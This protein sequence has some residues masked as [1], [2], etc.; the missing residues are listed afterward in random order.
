MVG[1]V[2]D[3]KRGG[4]KGKGYCNMKEFID[5]LISRLEIKKEVYT[6]V[7]QSMPNNQVVKGKVT[8][9]DEVIESVNQLAEEYNN[10]WIPCSD[11]MP[12]TTG[13]F[14]VT[15]KGFSRPMYAWWLSTEKKWQYLNSTK[16]IDDVIAWQPLPAPY[17]PENQK[18]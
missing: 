5:K 12:L 14:L 16:E 6:D 13:Y 18:Q 11:K 10:G 2:L 15:I 3:V 8:C 4:L 9:L 1:N 7:L 17:Q